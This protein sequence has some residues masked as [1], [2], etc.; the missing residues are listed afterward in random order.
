MS[1]KITSFGLQT[2]RHQFMKPAKLNLVSL[3]DIFTILV[4]FLLLNS[5]TNEIL[6]VNDITLP[7]STAQEQPRETTVVMITDEEILV[8]GR[9]VAAMVDV[10]NSNGLIDGLMA[11]LKFQASKRTELTEEEKQLGRQVTILGDQEIPYE[12][13]KRVM[14]TC[15][16]A[17]YRDLSM[18]VSRV[19]GSSGA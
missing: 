16:K 19:S 15:A 1:G 2:S 3:M 12:I 18:A 4:F 9:P 11:E 17:N 13:L 10:V 6:R 14:L 7:D 8:D 5:G